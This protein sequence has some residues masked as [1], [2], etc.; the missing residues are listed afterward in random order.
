[1]F[2]WSVCIVSLAG[3][4]GNA[5]GDFPPGLVYASP[6]PGSEWQ[7]TES[8]II[9]RFEEAVPS[10]LEASIEG[11][12]SGQTGFTEYLSEDGSTLVLTPENP[13][14]HG[15]TVTVTLER[16]DSSDLSAEWSFS[17]R[18][19]DPPDMTAE[20]ALSETCGE[21]AALTPE[22]APA[23]P[24]LLPGSV[25]LPADFP[26]FTFTTFGSPAPG[27]LFFG[28]MNP[29]G[30]DTS[31]YLIIA[32]TGG[33]VLF[34]RHSHTGFYDP[35]VQ[36]DGYLYYICGSLN[37][38]GVRWIQLDQA[39]AKVDSFSV[40][41][42]PTDIHGMTVAENG[43]VLLIGADRRYVDMSAIVPG[44]D[45][46]ALVQGLLIQE[47]DRNHMP[48]FQWSSFDHF[49]ITDAC[50]YVDLTGSFVDYVHCNS[51][52]E[53]SDGGILVSCLAMTECTKIDRSTGE[54]VWRLGG[55]MSENPSFTLLN[56]PLGG[57]S[58]QHDFRHV[59]GNLYSV[60]DNGPHHSP[61]IS[62][63]SV[64][65]LDTQEMTADLAWNYQM[66]GM[67]GSHMGSMQVLQNGNVE[68]G[69][70]DVTGYQQR[71]DISEISPSGSVVFTGRLN[72]ILLESYRAMK[73]DW[74]G[75]AVVPYL[76]AL[77]RPAQS[78]VQLTYNVFGEIPYSSYDI[79]QGTNPGS[80]SFLQNTA[81]N[82]INVWA[83]PT[84][85]NYF[86][87]KAR[88]AQGVPTGFSNI[89]SAYVSWTGIDDYQTTLPEMPARIGVFPNPAGSSFTVVWPGEPGG[90]A[91]VE[92][93]DCTGRAAV[94]SVLDPGQSDRASLMMQTGELPA[95]LYLVSVRSGAF[96]GVTR[97]V[98]L[99]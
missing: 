16:T 6:V 46:D 26:L 11:T 35:E 96:S 55:Y 2:I 45:P 43:N 93:L 81:L 4:A 77:A 17:V 59:S 30:G 78:C 64:Y 44:G 24:P 31:F 88:D 7:S 71:P 42:Y 29:V 91:V 95:G 76:V 97:L 25:S 8:R 15:E 47:Q 83:L 84:G 19:V 53:D 21:G 37:A 66:T 89:D 39:Y 13:F 90:E 33:Q 23:V 3:V 1:M 52:D 86:R 36:S 98:I 49:E 9:L 40:I 27:N 22:P 51:I 68:V 69:W 82:Q 5:P 41:G 79:Y 28:P 50:S 12:A 61:Q 92:L 60:F 87:V 14:T 67:Y 85:M 65:E 70:G 56:D 32:D 34:Y 74:T 58:S 72:Q 38:S 62:R 10:G 75:Q 63:A 94:R 18:P 73:F 48:V 57:F 54:L 99:R 20:Q 80:L